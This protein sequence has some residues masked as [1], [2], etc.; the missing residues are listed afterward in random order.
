MPLGSAGATKL[1]FQYRKTIKAIVF[2]FFFVAVAGICP[3]PSYCDPPLED[4]PSLSEQEAEHNADPV[5]AANA[6]YDA[7]P[8]PPSNTA[9]TPAVHRS[10]PAPDKTQWEARHESIGLTKQHTENLP[11]APMGNVGWNNIYDLSSPQHPP[12]P[13]TNANFAAMAM[14]WADAALAVGTAPQSQIVSA[15]SNMQTQLQ[16]AANAEAAGSINA[17][18]EALAVLAGSNINVANEASGRPVD[19]KAPFR[20]VSQAIWMVQQMFHHV[21]LPMAVLM[22]LPGAMLLNLKV[23][24]SRGAGMQGDED[25]AAGPFTAILRCVIAV[26]LIPATQ[27]IMSYSIDIGN[28]LTYETA[29]QIPL[30][31]IFAW[32]RGQYQHEQA[33]AATAAAQSSHP[34]LPPQPYAHQTFK[35]FMNLINMS[36]GYGLLILMAFQTIVSC[37]LLLLGPIAASFYAWPGG[38]GRLFRTVFA[39]WVDAVVNIALWRFWWILLVLCAITRI[40]WL[41]DIGEY[42]PNTEWEALMFT[43]FLVMMSYVPFMPFEL[44]PGALVD[45]LLEKAKQASGGSGGSGG[46]AGQTGAPPAVPNI[47]G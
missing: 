38:V 37:Y 43:C 5:N 40:Q 12:T 6:L 14:T 25:S 16:G 22:L 24:A 9:G 26:F 34:A 36:L 11:A 15:V 1:N 23:L 31:E 4:T 42:V 47:S 28:S 32:A 39:N 46:P 10:R 18:K 8:R 44:K 2:L 30:E 7:Q 45:K 35:A 21:Y 17:L 19:I 3:L 29:K 27:L 20:P 13:L 33:Q 41:K